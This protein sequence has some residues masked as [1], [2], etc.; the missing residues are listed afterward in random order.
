MCCGVSMVRLVGVALWQS[1]EQWHREVETA[2]AASVARLVRGVILL[3]HCAERAVVL[4]V[5]VSG[6]MWRWW[7]GQAGAGLGTLRSPAV[8][9]VFFVVV[10]GL[11]GVQVAVGAHVP[12]WLRYNVEL[13]RW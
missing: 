6:L 4:Y 12:E 8:R 9:N 13:G 2:D 10:A 11:P 7:R 3:S 1:A 5:L